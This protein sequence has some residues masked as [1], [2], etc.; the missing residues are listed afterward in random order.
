MPKAKKKKVEVVEGWRVRHPDRQSWRPCRGREEESAPTN[1][2]EQEGEPSGQV[3]D[4]EKEKDKEA[5]KEINDVIKLAR[6]EVTS[7]KVRVRA[8]EAGVRHEQRCAEDR[9]RRR[10][11]AER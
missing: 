6:A 5:L 11:A 8:A 2:E 1:M 7:T 9:E 3:E 4:S 10:D